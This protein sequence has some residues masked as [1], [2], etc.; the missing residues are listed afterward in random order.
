MKSPQQLATLLALFST[1]RPVCET[2]DICQALNC[3]RAT[4]YRHL[5]ALVEEGWLSK[6]AAGRYALG[7]RIA[8]LHS[9]LALS[10]PLL[11]TA[12]PAL[13]TLAQ[14]SAWPVAL[15]APCGNGQLLDVLY[16]TAAH[17]PLLQG[18]LRTQ[19]P[20]AAGCL[21]LGQ[22]PAAQQQQC[23]ATHRHAFAVYEW[24]RHWPALQ[25]QL[26]TIAQHAESV[27]YTPDAHL[28][29]GLALPVLD[30]QGQWVATVSAEARDLA[31]ALPVHTLAAVR[32]QLQD[33]A[34]EIRKALSGW[35]TAA[36]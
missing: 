22:S 14:H 33:A 25:A 27:L 34:W 20:S 19:W 9:V 21:W 26:H 17:Q 36:A 18:R 2:E 5:K 4:G 16:T 15:T 13:H 11:T 32:Q 35:I 31:Q 12:Q 29:Q 6:V 3:S 24:G 7:L 23:Y 8:Q 1:Q 28:L 10:H 30:P